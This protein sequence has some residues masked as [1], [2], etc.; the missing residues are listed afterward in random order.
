MKVDGVHH[1]TYQQI[2]NEFMK[3]HIFEMQRKIYMLFTGREVH[4]EKNCARGLEYGC[5]QDQ[6]HSFFPYGPT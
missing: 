3:D 6:G 2:A 5:T 4:M 1:T